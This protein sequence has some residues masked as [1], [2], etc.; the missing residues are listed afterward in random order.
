[1]STLIQ[2]L[3]YG[4][5]ML[6]KAA[7]STVVASLLLVMNTANA[8]DV[9][10]LIGPNVLVSRATNMPRVE[11][12]IAANPKNSRNLI[13]T[14]ISSEQDREDCRVY[15]TLDGGSTWRE[16][17]FLDL[18][19]TGSGDP[20]VAFDANGT[21]Y[22]TALGEVMASDGKNHFSLMMF[23]SEDGGLHWEKGAIYGAGHA[24]DHDQIVVASSPRGSEIYVAAGYQTDAE[25]SNV[26]VFRSS[27]GGRTMN[28]PFQ[29]AAGRGK[30]LFALNPIVFSD[31]TLFVPF[32]VSEQKP[33]EERAVPG[34]EIYFVTSRDDGSTY[35]EPKKIRNQILDPKYKV[36]SPYANILFAVDTTSTKYRDRLYMLWGEASAGHYHLNFSYSTDRGS[37]WSQAIEVGAPTPE[38]NQFRPAMAVNGEGVVGVSWFDTRDSNEGRHYNEYFAVSTDGGGTFMAPRRVS[39]ADSPLDVQGNSILK[40]TIDSP[41]TAADGSI[42]FS[43]MTTGGRFPDSGDYMGLA[44]D[45]DGVFHPFWSDT[46]TGSSQAWTARVKVAV[47][48]RDAAEIPGKDKAPTALGAK[49]L[50]IFD[51]GRYDAQSGTEEIPVRLQNVSSQQVCAPLTVR[52][53]GPDSVVKSEDGAQILNADNGKPWGGA[54]FNYSHALGEFSC[55]APGEVT[56][57]VMWKVRAGP[58]AETF[59]SFDVIVSGIVK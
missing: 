28:G 51:P 39:N 18:P 9:K 2:D 27:D 14:A 24:P 4:L 8:Q 6:T 37:T 7:G 29:A 36:G 32:T 47:S 53:K 16:I 55:L 25:P 49:I 58:S 15:T 46:R 34:V 56:N 5:R 26:G 42:S 38:A 23:R 20:Q 33:I 41:R 31:G 40:P 59:V 44:A 17:S 13:G 54:V 35:S 45:A 11:L 19:L 52:I 21:A 57:A 50:P 43:F 48:S 12:Q 10:I 1:M 30:G 22:F 3:R